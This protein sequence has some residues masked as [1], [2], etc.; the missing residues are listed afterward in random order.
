MER[1]APTAHRERTT[2]ELIDATRPFVRDNLARSWFNLLSGL[3]LLAATVTVAAV[4]PNTLLGLPLRALAAVL[5]G[6]LIV[7]IFVIYH[8]FIHGTILRESGLARAILYAFGVIVMTPPRVWRETH[9]YHHAHT[10]KIAGSHIGSYEMATVDDWG[11]MSRSAR[12]R[13]RIGR[14][15]LT[16]LFGYFTIFML[17][18]CVLPLLRAPRKN[19]D[20]GLS[21]ALNLALTALIVGSLGVATF[22]F[23]L[24]IPLAVATALGAYLF[25]AQHN[26]PEVHI[27]DAEDEWSFGRAALESSSYLRM[28]RVMAWFTGNIGYHHVHHLNSRIPFYRLPEA[29]AAIP[30]LQSPCETTLRPRDVAASFRLK[31]WDEGS[32]RMVGYTEAAGPRQ[33]LRSARPA[34]IIQGHEPR[35]HTPERA[36]ARN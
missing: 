3:A 12:L 23:T 16:I 25:Y 7:R 2:A 19:W 17:G 28:G 11:G 35:T 8:D 6:L 36:A 26:V 30:E 29:M 22:A 31:L 5:A 13:Y 27:Q 34:A 1:L 14:H 9:R 20:S 4:T 15:P 24:F 21:I 18:M 33:T 32:Q 10:A